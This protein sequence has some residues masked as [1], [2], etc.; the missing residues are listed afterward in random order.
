MSKRRNCLIAMS[1]KSYGSHRRTLRL[2]YVAYIRSVFEYGAAVYFNHAAPAVREK[3]ETEQ[4]KCA[5][6]ITGCIRLTNKETLAA[7][8]NLQPLS[9]R[10]KELAALEYARI[11]R[12]PEEDPARRLLSASPPPRHK[13]KAHEAWLKAKATANRAGEPSPP[14]PDE[15]STLPH[16]TCLRRTSKWITREAGLEGLPVEPLALFQGDPPWKLHEDTVSFVM[17]L[18]RVTKRTDPPRQTQ[19]GSTGSDR[20]PPELRLHHLLGRVCKGLHS[21]WRGRGADPAPPR[22]SVSGVH[23]PGWSGVQ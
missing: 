19:D 17:N 7:E 15:D 1:E 3:L 2:A 9:V 6:L 16:R 11:T 5:R 18:P 22:G 20:P 23:G 14:P 8:A 10:A 12:L 4:R 21:V 13:N